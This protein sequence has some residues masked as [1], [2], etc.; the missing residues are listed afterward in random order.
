MSWSTSVTA[1]RRCILF[2]FWVSW[3]LLQTFTIRLIFHGELVWSLSQ[4]R[5]IFILFTDDYSSDT[6]TFSLEHVSTVPNVNEHSHHVWCWQLWQMYDM[7]LLPCVPCR[8]CFYSV[9][10]L[11]PIEVNVNAF[12]PRR[13][14]AAVYFTAGFI[15][16]FHL[17][18][19]CS[20]QLCTNC[21][22][23][24]AVSFMI[25]NP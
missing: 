15:S 23:K 5:L 1:Q 19:L 3:P 4:L 22:N 10:R 14:H 16:C 13:C 11:R 24:N 25:I 2:F 6:C 18:L 20:G 7:I 17:V 12:P 8:S 9:E 21:E